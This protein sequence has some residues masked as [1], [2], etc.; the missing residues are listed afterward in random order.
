MEVQSVGLALSTV[1]RLVQAPDTKTALDRAALL[2][3]VGQLGRYASEPRQHVSQ[4]LAKLMPL[5]KRSFKQPVLGVDDLVGLCQG[6]AAAGQY[7]LLGECASKAWR[8]NFSPI[9]G[10]YDELARCKGDPARLDFH[11]EG[12]L[13]LLLDQARFAKDKR[14]LALIDQ[15]LQQH[16][17]SRLPDMDF[18]FS[19]PE[20]A[21]ERLEGLD[22]L[23]PFELLNQVLGGREEVEKLGQLPEK[24]AMDIV[25]RKLIGLAEDEELPIFPSPGGGKP[26]KRR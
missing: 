8:R 23:D 6:L 5:L 25:M 20:Q 17:E 13:R 16:E 10:Y 22:K 15:F 11:G 9:L 24:E 7:E 14:A 1:S 12:R 21:L 4:A 3:L 19:R 18:P 2:A 26:R